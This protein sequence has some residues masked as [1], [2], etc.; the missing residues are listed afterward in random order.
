MEPGIYFTALVLAVAGLHLLNKVVTYVSSFR[1]ASGLRQNSSKK[2]ST[3]RVDWFVFFRCSDLTGE[4]EKK[5]RNKQQV[6]KH[7]SSSPSNHKRRDRRPV[8][9]RHLS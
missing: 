7:I 6:N 4:P 5:V 9:R 2:A 1:A 8:L 3:Q